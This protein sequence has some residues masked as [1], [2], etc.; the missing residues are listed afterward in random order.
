MKHY[1]AITARGLEHMLAQELEQLGVSSV[2]QVHAGVKFKADDSTLYQCCLWSRIASRFV[3]VLGEFAVRDDMDLYLGATAINWPDY[4]HASQRI[5]V[6]F[7]GTNREIRNSQYGALKVKDAIVDKFEKS[8][9]PRPSVDREQPDLRIHMR[10]SKDQGLL[11]IDMVGS[12]LHQRGYRTQAGAAPLRETHAAALVARSGWKVD[13]PLMDIM[14]GS[15]TLLIEAA[16]MAAKIAPGLK[17]KRWGFESLLG[18]DDEAFKAIK[19]E[20]SVKAKRGVSQCQTR[21]YGTDNDAR[22]IETARANARRAGVGELIDFATGDATQVT[23][24]EGFSGGHILSNPPYG[25][26]L[27]TTPGLIAL[28]TQLGDHLKEAFAGNTV[29]LYSGS[30][31]LLSCLR[32]RADD[33]FKL[34]NGALDCVMKTYA[35]TARGEKS[36]S[37]APKADVAPDFANRLRKNMAK[38][39]KWAKK[40]A[41]ECYRLYD[42]DLPDYKAAIDR[43][44]DYLVIQEYAAPKTIEPEKARRRLLDM[45]RAAIAVTGVDA[46]K[47]VL[48]TREKQKG[49]NQY[50]KLAGASR[51]MTVHEYGVALEVNLYDYLDTGVFLDHRNTRRLIGEKAQGKDFLNLFAYTGSAS[52]HAA[53]GGARSTTTVDMSKTYI[54]WAERNMA[55][56]GIVGRQHRFEQADCLQWI[57]QSDQQFDLIF[58]DPPT[59]SNSKRMHS[60]FDV[61]RDHLDVLLALKDRLRPDGEIIFS[62]NKRHF[63]MDL[64]GLAAAGLSAENISKRS[65]PED[66]AR[67]P[68]I[69]NCWIIRHQDMS[70]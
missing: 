70:A 65:I 56:N 2:K 61:Q 36:E 7:N 41:L 57:R 6:D 19:A 40:Q 8:N 68:H 54:A 51:T 47:V 64:E 31:E 58:I 5:A 17:R 25:E 20:A 9:L 39:D 55:L 67:N 30:E 14:C 60:T 62:N 52:V 13:Q 27:G 42:A 15:G 4:F 29:S 23:P 16:M 53:V 50:Q 63:K 35:I 3:L 10:L 44:R 32:M 46:N 21:F 38:L 26:R 18:F 49:N 66:F 11:G 12:G 69:H 33:K 48:K 59:F 1:L 37:E 28:Y 43:Y 22:M 24:P 45:V 34:R